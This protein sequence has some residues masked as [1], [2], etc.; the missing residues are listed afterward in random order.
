MPGLRRHHAPATAVVEG[1]VLGVVLGVWQ[2]M[3]PEVAQ[4]AV[5]GAAA[6]PAHHVLMYA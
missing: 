5:C 4:M 6:A 2:A 1:V 3:A